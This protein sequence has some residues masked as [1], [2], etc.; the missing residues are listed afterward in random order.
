MMRIV[1]VL[2]AALSTVAAVAVA[3]DFSIGA[4]EMAN[5]GCLRPP[6]ARRWRAAT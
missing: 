6:R 1:F 2:A 5:P 4:I 3:E